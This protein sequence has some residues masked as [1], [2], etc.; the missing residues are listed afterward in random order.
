VVD[1]GYNFR[2][3]EIRSS[4]LL[5]QLRRLDDFLDARRGHVE[6]YGRCLDGTG[7]T[8]PSFD[9]DKL[10]R[11]GDTV[12]YHIMP[13]LLPASVDRLKVMGA[14]R[15]QGVQS[16]IHYPPV[17]LFSSFRQSVVTPSLPRTEALAARELTL[18]LYPSMNADQIRHVCGSLAKALDVCKNP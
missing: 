6:L 5:A 4:L 3:D 1:L 12:G 13:V 9:W 11:R 10:G 18:P 7:V 8:I 2:L 14:M 16:S 17:H 15:D